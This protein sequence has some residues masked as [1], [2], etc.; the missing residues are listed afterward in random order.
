MILWFDVFYPNLSVVEYRTLHCRRGLCHIGKTFL[1]CNIL[2][3]N[4][5]YLYVGVYSVCVPIEKMSIKH[6]FWLYF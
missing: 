6:I 2:L 1:F 5:W 3:I 4:Q